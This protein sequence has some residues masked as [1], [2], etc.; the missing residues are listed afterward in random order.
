MVCLYNRA[1][2][3]DRCVMCSYAAILVGFRDDMVMG[4]EGMASTI[5]I[6]HSPNFTAALPF[7]V[8]VTGGNAS[9]E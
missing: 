5:C 4:D 9:G 6:E 2:Q 3:K 7:T 8:T 1:C